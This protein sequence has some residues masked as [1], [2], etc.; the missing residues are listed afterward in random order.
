M[1]TGTT[2]FLQDLALVGL[3]ILT[4]GLLLFRGWCRR[5]ARRPETLAELY[6]QD[7]GE[8]LTIF[9]KSPRP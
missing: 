2:P 1:I 8:A 5:R 7:K 9:H 3:P 6:D 4:V